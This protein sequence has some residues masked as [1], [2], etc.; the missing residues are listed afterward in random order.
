[1]KMAI[2]LTFSLVLI[3]ELSSDL[4]SVDPGDNVFLA[5]GQLM[6]GKRCA[7]NM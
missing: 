4:K 1:M 5:F 3:L 6:G 2:I 7:S